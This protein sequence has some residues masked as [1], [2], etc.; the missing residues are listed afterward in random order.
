[1]GALAYTLIPV[2]AVLLGSIMAIVRR[3]GEALVS[4]MQHLAAGVVFA[5]AATEILPPVLHRAS[6]M[7]TLV[8]GG[9]GVMVMLGL[10]RIEE[11]FAGKLALV[12]TVG[13]DILVDGL[14]L[15][16]AFLAG[17]KAGLLLTIALTLEVLFLGLSVTTELAEETRSKP[18]VIATVA[19][20][21][22]ML[23]LGALAA[24]PLATL[25]P[26]VIAGFLSFGLMALL[27]LVTEELLVE[28]HARRDTPLISAMFFIGFLVLLLIEEALG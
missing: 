5:A 16:L 10:K 9:L 4:A 6:P 3:P 2:A 13:L 24:V 15:G 12:A 28:A 20:L 22:L 19:L 25:P 8:G 17:A 18:R 1:M 21:A 14:V 27:Y 7:A 11:R 26:V 23:P